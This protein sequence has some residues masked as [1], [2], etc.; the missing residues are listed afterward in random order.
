MASDEKAVDLESVYVTYWNRL[1]HSVFLSFLLLA[2]SVTTAF[3]VIA[4]LAGHVSSN[5]L[6]LISISPGPHSY[7]TS[8]KHKTSFL[9]V[10]DVV[11]SPSQVGIL[12]VTLLVLLILFFSA[13]FPAFHH[14][15]AAIGLSLIVISTLSLAVFLSAHISTP[16]RPSD[17]VV[18]TFILIFAINTMMPL[19]RWL[20]V[21]LS[22]L[23]VAIHLFLAGFLSTE[24]KVS[25]LRQVSPFYFSSLPSPNFENT[26]PIT[27]LSAVNSE[28][29]RL[30]TG[31]FKAVSIS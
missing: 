7:F 29:R 30:S 2:S 28:S 13:Q 3:L 11:S 16:T 23:L 8:S 9:F 20:A 14:P 15:H 5:S 21:G 31:G 17:H 27:F 6:F 25:L 19:P 4:A 12:L 18:S 1:Q 22:I 26:S 10:Q 24:Y